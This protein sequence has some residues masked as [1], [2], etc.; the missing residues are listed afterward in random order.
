MSNNDTNSGLPSVCSVLSSASHTPAPLPSLKT[1]LPSSRMWKEP[2]EDSGENDDIDSSCPLYSVADSSNT[3]VPLE[4]MGGVADRGSSRGPP[5][6]LIVDYFQEATSYQALEKKVTMLQDKLRQQQEELNQKSMLLE[7]LQSSSSSGTGTGPGTNTDAGADAGTTSSHMGANQPSEEGNKNKNTSRKPRGE[8]RASSSVPF[9]SSEAMTLFTDWLFQAAS[10]HERLPDFVKEYA[11][12]LTDIGLPVHRLTIMTA[13]TPSPHK[14]TIFYTS[15]WQDGD[16]IERHGTPTAQQHGGDERML[17]LWEEGNTKRPVRVR[18]SSCD[19][20]VA[21]ARDYLALP[22]LHKGVC[23]GG[24]AWSSNDEFAGE[25]IHF[26]EESHGA[27][28][29]VLRSYLNDVCVQHLQAHM[30]EEI[31]QRTRELKEMNEQLKHANQ[32]IE[33]QSGQQLKHFA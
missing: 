4:G 16:L 2:P 11:H 23:R 15:T 30:D 9:Q 22:V 12:F 7:K 13:T 19:N 1:P 28:V 27:L 24:L 20:R 26:L 10:R 14:G 8:H 3:T 32:R 5:I 21:G 29:A 31:A 33:R 18:R 6:P 25:H 17:R